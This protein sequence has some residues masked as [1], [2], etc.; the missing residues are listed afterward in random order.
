M[1]S[2]VAA[3]LKTCCTCRQ[4]LSPEA[5]HRDRS[6]P[7]GRAPR[8]R[9]CASANSRKYYLKNGAKAREQHRAWRKANPERVRDT[10]RAWRQANVDRARA[11]SRK[12]QLANPDKYKASRSKWN[13]ANRDKHREEVARRRALERSAPIEIELIRELLGSPCAYCGSLEYIE[14][15]HIVPLSRGG[16]HE[17]ENLAPAC[18]S[19]N[20][21]KGAKLLSEWKVAA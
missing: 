5:F 18:R 21:S 15:D 8:C 20:R 3:S 1:M 13:Q 11:Y 12:W 16:L 7:D 9:A 10:N 4:R 2:P 6:R 14:I 17:P 19:C